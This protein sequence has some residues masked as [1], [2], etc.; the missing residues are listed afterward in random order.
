MMYQCYKCGAEHTNVA[1]PKCNWPLEQA[2]SVNDGGPAFP[3]TA[4][5]SFTTGMSLRDVFGAV[6]M[7]GL[8][9]HYGMEEDRDLTTE[10]AWMQAD[11]MLAA[12]QKPQG[13]QP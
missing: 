3:T 11:A 10:E 12:R 1:C 6:A 2:G 5:T 4:E 13:Q 9:A 8:V 7:L